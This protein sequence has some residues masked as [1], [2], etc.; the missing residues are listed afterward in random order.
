MMVRAGGS[1]AAGVA[2]CTISVRAASTLLLLDEAQV[3]Y[4]ISKSAC[5]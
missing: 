5:S 1:D 3:R 2:R 4:S